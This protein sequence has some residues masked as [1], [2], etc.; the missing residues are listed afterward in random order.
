MYKMIL[1][2]AAAMV[3]FAA[4]TPRTQAGEYG[5]FV[6]R[7]PTDVAIHYQVKWGDGEWKSYT[8]EPGEKRFHAYSLDK[9][10]TIPSPYV[11]FDY[12]CGDGKVTYKSYH[13][14]CYTCGDPWRGKSNHFAYSPGGNYLYLY[15][16]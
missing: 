7:N 2:S 5:S 11:R 16:D 6:M 1:S 14:E 9:D 15:D 10:N 8:V 12:I 13:M 4:Q 3:L